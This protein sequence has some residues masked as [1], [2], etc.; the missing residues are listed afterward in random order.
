MTGTAGS[1]RRTAQGLFLSVL[2]V[3]EG[4][5][6][7]AVLPYCFL[8]CTLF[9]CVTWGEQSGLFRVSFSPNGHGLMTLLVSFLVIS[10][11][12]LAYDRFREARRSVGDAFLRLRELCQLVATM[13]EAAKREAG[14]DDNQ[15]LEKIEAWKD[16]SVDKVME[17]LDATYTVIQSK[18]LARQLARNEMS[19]DGATSKVVGKDFEDPMMIVQTLRLHLYMVNDN[20]Q[21]LE[22]V[23]LITKLG[24]FVSDY[25]QCLQLASTP[26]PF[27]LVQMGRV[28]LCIWTFSMPLVLREGPFSDMWSA[29]VFLFFLTYGFIGLE[30]V[31]MSLAAPFGDGPSD[32]R[33]TA[34]RDAVFDGIERDLAITHAAAV[35][36][37][38]SWATNINRRS[39]FSQQK[40]PTSTSSVAM[41]TDGAQGG[42][43]AFS[44][45]YLHLP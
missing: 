3:K 16:A 5:V 40:N 36:M 10:K 44:S 45:N 25:R 18:R 39:R 42:N 24:E 17:L 35:S 26:L 22:R 15:E 28:F 2:F 34:L 30:L 19:D 33:V 41:G 31:A 9:G 6:L 43:V 13:A 23:Q 32:I 1:F 14:A 27:C 12:N 7:C 8:N 38:N 4:N 11:V 21:L 20:F 37:S 29:M